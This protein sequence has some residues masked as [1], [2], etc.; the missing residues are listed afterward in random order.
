MEY[1]GVLGVITEEITIQVVNK[2][3]HMPIFQDHP[4]T[5]EIKENTPVG[6]LITI[7]QLQTLTTTPLVSTSPISGNHLYTES[8]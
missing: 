7:S 6:S 3:I 4:K 2:N 8:A 1:D 5:F